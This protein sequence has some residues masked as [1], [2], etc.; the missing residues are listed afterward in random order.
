MGAV[1]GS[2]SAAG[3]AGRLQPPSWLRTAQPRRP[4]AHRGAR[5]GPPARAAEP[6][7]APSALS[8]NSCAATS[9]ARCCT[10]S[11][12]SGA[13]SCLAAALSAAPATARSWRST[14]PALERRHC[15]VVPRLQLW[16]PLGLVV[17]CTCR[18]TRGTE[19]TAAVAR[20]V[21]RLHARIQ[22]TFTSPCCR[23]SPSHLS[24][25]TLAHTCVR[26]VRA[27]QQPPSVFFSCLFREAEG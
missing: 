9:R 13:K 1:A 24:V 23:F 15:R 6:G 5:G 12:P 19:G 14:Q 22:E 18:G 8:E 2:S 11:S 26:L 3:A 27:P 17:V 7:S 21:Q 4:A 16:R 20:P 10:C 25:R